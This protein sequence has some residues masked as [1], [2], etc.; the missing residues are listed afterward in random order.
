MKNNFP[1]SERFGN[2]RLFL[3]NMD[4][5]RKR[6]AIKRSFLSRTNL[7]VFQGIILFGATKLFCGKHDISSLYRQLY[8]CARKQFFLQR[9]QTSRCSTLF[10]FF[11]TKKLLSWLHQKCEQLYKIDDVR[12]RHLGPLKRVNLSVLYTSFFVGKCKSQRCIH[13]STLWHKKIASLG[14]GRSQH[15]LGFY[16]FCNE[17][18]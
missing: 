2:P 6:A 14:G 13:D 3:Q 15:C 4:M 8:F 17:K 18:L 12:R 16:V 5:A 11:G 7:T 9:H 1:K 10:Y